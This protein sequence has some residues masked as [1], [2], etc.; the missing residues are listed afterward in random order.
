MAIAKQ[1]DVVPVPAAALPQFRQLANGFR[2]QL[3]A[4][5]TH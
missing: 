2:N 5:A 3:Q 1:S 4:A